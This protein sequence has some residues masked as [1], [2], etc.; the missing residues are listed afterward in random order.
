MGSVTSPEARLR[1][2]EDRLEVQALAAR[3]S[4]AYAWEVHLLATGVKAGA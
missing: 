2:V 1:T 4:D 3:F